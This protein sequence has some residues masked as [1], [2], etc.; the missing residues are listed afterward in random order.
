MQA[1]EVIAGRFRLDR[2]LGSGGMGEVWAATHTMTRK[3]WALKFLHKGSE[4]SH[5]SSERLVREARAASAVHHPGVVP[6]VD[7]VD[8]EGAPVL[9]MELLNGESLRTRLERESQMS[10]AETLLVVEPILEML[11]AAHAAGVVHRDLKPDNVFLTIDAPHTRLLD[12]GVAKLM[13]TEDASTRDLTES[14]AMLG[15]PYYMAPEQAFGE[16]DVDGRADLWAL[17]VLTFE[18]LTGERPTQGENLGQ[19]MRILATGVLPKLAS[20]APD[21]SRRLGHV[22]DSLLEVDRDKRPA[23]ARAVLDMLASRHDRPQKRTPRRLAMFAGLAAVVIGGAAVA[24]HFAKQ[25][26]GPPI[27]SQS[28]TTVTPEPPRSELDAATIPSAQLSA[29]AT[30]ASVARVPSITPK[31]AA[32]LT[33]SASAQNPL[34]TRPPF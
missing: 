10:E 18:C 22:V 9:V 29:P 1:G 14:G 34:L 2:A 24:S 16:R 28:N 33:P 25:N 20:R 27:A 5:R 26:D 31:P 17:G 3:T 12:F 7:V 23:S 6:I 32:T 11:E 8:H 13:P 15:T 30:V 19:V 21:V 4:S